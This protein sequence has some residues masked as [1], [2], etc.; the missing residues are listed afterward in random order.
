MAVIASPAKAMSRRSGRGIFG[1]GRPHRATQKPDVLTAPVHILRLIQHPTSRPQGAPFP[2]SAFRIFFY[3]FLV[4][5][6]VT[7]IFNEAENLDELSKRLFRVFSGHAG[8]AWEWIAVDDGSTDGGVEILDGLADPPCHLRIVRLSRNFGQQAALMAGLQAASGGAVLFL[9]GDLQDP[10]E[11][12]PELVKAWEGGAEVVIARR[13]KRSEPFLRRT[14]IGAFHAVFGRLTGNFMPADTGNFGLLDKKVADA[15][16]A[17][18]EH[19]LYLPGLRAWA[20]FRRGEIHYERSP[21]R[22]GKP[23]G[24][25][26][27]LAF[28]WDALLAFSDLPLRSI[29][30]LGVVISLLS[31]TYAGWLI[32]QR[33]LQFLGFFKDLEVLG[34]TTIAVSVFFM[35]GVQ[36]VCL[37][38]IGE[39][40]ARIYREVKGRPRYIVSQILEK[41]PRADQP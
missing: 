28:G 14:L 8:H 34:F 37:G 39:Y 1:A 11:V 33:V 35:G 4:I 5:S 19:T 24:V 17:M 16:R 2:L 41:R 10:P 18:P 27:L 9:D 7:P 26:K 13:S 21:R 12:I 36:L 25:G 20:G 32:I 38:V 31:F 22:R 3:L 40:L 29:A 6:I 23:L 15:V 30:A